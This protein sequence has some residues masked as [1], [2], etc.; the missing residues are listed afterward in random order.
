M[1]EPTLGPIRFVLEHRAQGG[2]R[3]P[4]LRVRRAE[5]ERELLRFDCF[6][7]SPHYHIDPPGRNEITALDPADDPIAFTL[8][9][10]ESDPEGLLKRAGLELDRPLDRSRL[11]D[12]LRTLEAE[13]RNP[14]V[15]LDRLDLDRLR[16]RR[17]EKW[18]VYAS[19]VLA[20]WVA[21]MDYPIPDPIRHVLLR[22]IERS[23]LGYPLD[24][25]RLGH[26][27]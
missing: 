22:A 16:T 4:T 26:S 25:E 17:G 21:D 8:E 18:A 6:E 7:R 9:R 1:P 15:D 19:D 14:P 3:G 11:T 24:P 2:D 27:D 23:D 12:V 13:M 20:A 10:L 5:D